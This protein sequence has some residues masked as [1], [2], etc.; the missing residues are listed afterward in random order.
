MCTAAL[1]PQSTRQQAIAQQRQQELLGAAKAADATAH[2]RYGLPV[3]DPQGRPAIAHGSRV[4]IRLQH[5][6]GYYVDRI[7][8]WIKW[9][10]V[11]AGQMG[12]KY[13]GIYWDPPQQE[14]HQWCRPCLRPLLGLAGVPITV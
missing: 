8:A 2:E 9:A 7:P 6:G 1:C 13:D 4:K 3:A 12:A 14:R 11:A 5:P 10:T